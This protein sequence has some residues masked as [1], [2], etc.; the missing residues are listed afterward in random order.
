MKRIRLLLTASATLALLLGAS[1]GDEEGATSEPTPATVVAATASTA[2]TEGPTTVAT[3]VS[4]V[5][6]GSET[7]IPEASEVVA[8]TYTIPTSE[9]PLVRFERAAVELPVEV[10]PRSEYSIGLSG[11]EYL[12]RR[13][14]LFYRETFGQ[15]GFWMKNTHVDLDIAFV[16]ADRR[17]LFITTMYADTEDIHRPDSPYVVA[18]EAPAGWYAAHGVI[19]GDTVEY[20]FDLGATVRD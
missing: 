15:T 17:I 5:S 10:P 20:L 18:I 13:G 6:G 9:L 7:P 8:S 16:D 14:M 19:E 2:G 12:D 4:G 3:A 11:R 1:C